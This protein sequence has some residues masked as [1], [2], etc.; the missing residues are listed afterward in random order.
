MG[1]LGT[2]IL[3]AV[4]AACSTWLIHKISFH[5]HRRG[6][7]TESGTIEIGYYEVF[8]LLLILLVVFFCVF[9]TIDVDSGGTD[10]YVYQ[11]Q[12]AQSTGSLFEQLTRFEGWEPL[13]AVSLWI[14]RC[15]T[16]EYR[17]YLVLYYILMALFL[18]KYAKMIKLDRKWLL[19]T[20]ALMLLFLNSFNTQR[21]TFAVFASLF[22]LDALLKKKH[23]RA[24]IYVLV[25]TGFHFSALIWFVVI[26]ASVFIRFFRGSM[27][28]KLIGY[29]I[30]SSAASLA[31]LRLFPILA[32]DHRLAFYINA[33]SSLSIPMLFTFLFVFIVFLLYYR[34]IVDKS[35]GDDTVMLSILYLSFAPMFVLQMQYSILYRMMLYS[36]PVLYI[37]LA[38]YKEVFSKGGSRVSYVYIA[39]NLVY[40]LRIA[41]FYRDFADL[42]NYSSVLLR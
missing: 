37:V 21:N 19:A 6:P 1:Q 20:F 8:S 23:I 10:A 27:K 31:G 22:V 41:L 15:V 18:I 35:D 2:G 5:Y 14:V 34:M 17:V 42:G 40:L 9:R 11:T 32:G 16:E 39:C 24:A 36:I 7:K 25:I 4:F 38:K 29:M 28:R 13:H 33:G 26:G 3:F 30:V 12:F